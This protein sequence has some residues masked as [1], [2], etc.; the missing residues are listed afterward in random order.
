[1]R[2]LALVV[3]IFVFASFTNANAPMSINVDVS[4][5]LIEVKGMEFCIFIGK[6]TFDNYIDIEVVNITKEKLEVEKLK[7]EIEKLK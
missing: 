1:M 5:K 3:M 2:K 6:A 7:L 4:T